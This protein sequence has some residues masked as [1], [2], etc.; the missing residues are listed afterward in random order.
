MRAASALALVV[1]LSPASVPAGLNATPMVPAYQPCTP[2]A[3]SC[4]AVLESRFTFERVTLKSSKSPWV[5]DNAVAVIVELRGVRDEN[6]APVTTD[7][8]NPADDFHLII[9]GSQV[10]VGGTTVAPGILAPEI[11]IPIDLE[12]GNGKASYRTPAGGQGS[13]VVT[14]TTGVPYVRD[15]DGKRF[16]V[17]GARDKPAK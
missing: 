11:V 12:K 7:P 2:P 9:P 4:P 10:T 13:G 5:K 1:L 14:E 8:A 16:A 6:G 3:A 15:S 17:S